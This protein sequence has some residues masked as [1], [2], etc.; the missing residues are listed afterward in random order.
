MVLVLARSLLTYRLTSHCTLWVAQT[1]QEQHCQSPC[2]SRV[3]NQQ[4]VVK[5]IS[6]SQTS[7]QM[8][9]ATALQTRLHSPAD[10]RRVLKQQ[11]QQQQQHWRRAIPTRRER[12]TKSREGR[13][14]VRGR[15]R[16]QAQRQAR[17]Q[18]RRQGQYGGG[19]GRCGGRYGGRHGG[20][21]SATRT[22][23][24]A[25]CYDLVAGHLSVC[26]LVIVMIWWDDC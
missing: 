10:L 9:P 18:T 20:R 7:P 5:M 23:R 4:R 8:S 11:Q 26:G 6:D 17:R 25:T 15:W 3:S 21:G 16:R 2:P 19:G 14:R 1:C 24:N 13:R 22:R 12:K